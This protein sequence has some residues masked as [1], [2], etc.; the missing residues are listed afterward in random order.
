MGAPFNLLQNAM[1]ISAAVPKDI[2][3]AAYAGDYVNMSLCDELW[4]MLQQ[5]AWA[6]GTPAFTVGQGTTAAGGSTAALGTFEAWQG[7]ALTDDQYAAVTVTSGT[8]NLPAVANTVTIVRCRAADM[9]EGYKYLRGEVATPGANAD[10]FAMS[11][12]LV[13]LKYQGNVPPSVIA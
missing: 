3:G 10:L 4:I 1:W 8:F 12:V 6:G 13:G 11:Y 2:T 9:T 5:G 7:V